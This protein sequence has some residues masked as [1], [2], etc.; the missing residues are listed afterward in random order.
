MNNVTGSRYY[1]GL[2]DGVYNPSMVDSWRSPTMQNRPQPDFRA[3]NEDWSAQDYLRPTENQTFSKETGQRMGAGYTNDLYT[4]RQPIIS[5][6]EYKKNLLESWRNS[7][8]TTQTINGQIVASRT[9]NPSG[10]EGNSKWGA[11]TGSD[12]SINYNWIIPENALSPK[13]SQT[14]APLSDAQRANSF[15]Y[16]GNPSNLAIE[17]NPVRLTKTAFDLPTI[18]STNTVA[19]GGLTD[20]TTGE[21]FTPS[22]GGYSSSYNRFKGYAPTEINGIVPTTRNIQ[23]PEDRWKSNLDTKD[24][25][26]QWNDEWAQSKGFKDY[27][28]YLNRK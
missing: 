1:R 3:I 11:N 5:G 14:N 4:T 16:G 21:Q 23:K 15:N 22:T 17:Q 13:F 12:K 26:S 9:L 27:Q 28:D 19:S 24:L 8:L 25:T 6:Q 7:P 18:G 2:P 10:V 20:Y